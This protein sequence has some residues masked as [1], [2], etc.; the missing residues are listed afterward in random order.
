[1]ETSLILHG[2]TG[3]RHVVVNI[4][5]EHFQDRLDRDTAARLFKASVAN[6]EISISSYCNRVCP[7]CPNAVADRRSARNLIDDGVMASILDQLRSIGYAGR[8]ALHRYN[9]PLADKDYALRRVRE[10]RAALPDVTV[11]VVTNGD[12]L[13][14]EIVFELK[15]AGVSQI[16]ATTHAL[17]GETTP[18]GI[19]RRQDKALHRLGLAFHYMQT[20]EDARIAFVDAGEGMLVSWN[21]I[22][23]YYRNA[24]GVPNMLD[25]GQSLAFATNY[26]R[27]DPCLIPF[28]ELQVEWDGRVLP[29]CNIYPDLPEH[30]KYVLGRIE[31]D[32]DIF[33][34]WSNSRFVAWRKALYRYGP[35]AA[36]CTT[37][38]YSA[39]GDTPEQREDVRE[40]RRLFIGGDDDTAA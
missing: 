24:D 25:R 31:A 2:A 40:C 12:Y 29:C 26:S 10:I 13:T 37:C 22:D 19:F 9:E 16:L 21:A 36:P 39:T 18:D 15:A 17:T 38:H 32:T 30:E 28:T 20:R 33:L 14:K 7:Y 1:M 6:V 4:Y 34:L 23:Y 35:K 3:G 8:V 27:T 11:A 5:R